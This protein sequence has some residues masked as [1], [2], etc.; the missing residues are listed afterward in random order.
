MSLT[1][2]G[3]ILG[4]LIDPLLWLGVQ[5]GAGRRISRGVIGGPRGQVIVERVAV[6][7]VV[8]EHQATVIELE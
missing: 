4:V 3:Y 7:G 6:D 5:H 2:S 8:V 1:V